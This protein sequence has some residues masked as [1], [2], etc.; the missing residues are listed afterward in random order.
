MIRSMAVLSGLALLAAAP[1]AQAVLV[2]PGFSPEAA[3]TEANPPAAWSLRDLEDRALVSP[4]DFAFSGGNVFRFEVL[5]RGFGANKLEQCV[6]RASGEDFDFGA[7]LRSPHPAEGLAARFNIEFYRSEADCLEREDRLSIGNDDFD[8]DLDM[9][10]NV[11]A[12]FRSGSYDGS[13]LN[14]A[15]AQWARISLRIR[16]RSDDGNPSDPPRIVYIDH[17]TGPDGELL[18]NG[19]F[20]LVEFPALVEFDEDSGPLGWTMRDVEEG[21][22]VEARS[23]ARSQGRVFRF[24]QLTD[25]FGANKLEQCLAIPSGSESVQLSTWVRTPA[26]SDDLGVRLNMDFYPG[27][28]DCLFR[29]NRLQRTDSDIFLNPDN[30]A[31]DEWARIQTTAVGLAD[32]PANAGFVRLRI[33]ARDSSGAN[34]PLFFDDVAT[35][36]SNPNLTGPWF[37]PATRGQGFNLQTA[38]NG[39]FGFFY[40]YQDGQPLWLYVDVYSGPIVY[41]ETIDM[42]LLI[43]TGGTFGQPNVPGLRPW[44]R[45]QVRFDSC[46][47]A[48]MTLIGDELSQT[49]DA[50]LGGIVNGL[51]LPDCRVI[52]PTGAETGVSGAWLDPSSVGQGYNFLATPFG[53]LVYFY[54]Y[55]ADGEQLWVLSDVQ[56]F[57]LNE[58]LRLELLGARDGQ[59][60]APVPPA[61]LTTWGHL[62]ITFESCTQATARLEGLDGTDDQSLIMFAPIAGLP[63]CD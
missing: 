52:E 32:L 50:N 15:N 6:P 22:V 24:N 39:L 21:A 1:A 33:S 48:E 47:Q 18:T 2:N 41:G 10:A 20:S 49:L 29:E 55:T 14:S 27:L 19:D 31:A 37:D 44:G 45:L 36:L 53:L 63:G 61:E 58:P 59:F 7:W 60:D 57:S 5:Q 13:D 4:A 54:G 46:T 56:P 34:T 51:Q 28:E 30:F 25:N 23:F 62:D 8:V 12:P 9:P 35:N 43:G 3:F 11:W 17:L 42:A 16:D 26:P 38:P 40:G